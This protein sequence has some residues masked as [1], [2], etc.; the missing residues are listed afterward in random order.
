VDFACRLHDSVGQ[1]DWSDSFR[2]ATAGQKFDIVL[3]GEKVRELDSTTICYF[4]SSKVDI[5]KLLWMAMSQGLQGMLFI[6]R[7]P[8]PPPLHARPQ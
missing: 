7:C 1:T 4:V 3:K 8:W 5:V 2:I 6:C